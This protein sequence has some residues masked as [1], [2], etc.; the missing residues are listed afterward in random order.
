MYSMKKKHKGEK[1]L[2][3]LLLWI[4]TLLSI[5]IQNTSLKHA[6][7]RRQAHRNSPPRRNRVDEMAEGIRFL[8]YASGS[9]P[10]GACGPL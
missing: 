1:E 7:C 9:Q 3:G 2:T 5:D 10:F 8:G 6:G 4:N